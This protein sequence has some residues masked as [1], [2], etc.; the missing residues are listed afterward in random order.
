MR[1]DVGRRIVRVNALNAIPMSIM[2]LLCCSVSYWHGNSNNGWR[3]CGL[4]YTA[5]L[6][7][8]ATILVIVKP[9]FL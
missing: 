2:M 9:I 5:I 4:I 1:S 7:I 8:F 3:I 6:G